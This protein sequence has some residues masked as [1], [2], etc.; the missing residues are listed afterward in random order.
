MGLSFRN[1]VLAGL[2]SAGQLITFPAFSQTKPL[3]AT[4][5]KD[6]QSNV[7]VSPLKDVPLSKGFASKH[8]QDIV[9]DHV[10]ITQRYKIGGGDA[11]SAVNRTADFQQQDIYVSSASN[12][13]SDEIASVDLVERKTELFQ[14]IYFSVNSWDLETAGSKADKPSDVKKFDA[15][16]IILQRAKQIVA[17][18]HQNKHMD[19]LIVGHAS[20]T[21]TEEH[22]L[23][24]SQKRTEAVS[25][26][27]KNA[28]VA[29][30]SS[31]ESRFHL[32]PQSK[33]DLDLAVDTKKEN[34]KNRNVSILTITDEP[35]DIG[36]NYRVNHLSSDDIVKLQAHNNVYTLDLGMQTELGRGLG[37]S[38][39]TQM[40]T[41]A[42]GSILLETSDL[43]RPV[44][45]DVSAREA[46]DFRLLVNDPNAKLRYLITGDATATVFDNNRAIANLNYQTADK[47]VL[48]KEDVCVAAVDLKGG[49]YEKDGLTMARTMPADGMTREQS[50][51]YDLARR[52]D[53][54][55]N[56][57]ITRSE[58]DAYSA[59]LDELN[60]VLP[61]LK[62]A[63]RAVFRNEGGGV[64]G[65]RSQFSNLTCV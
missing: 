63:T 1:A 58:L 15:E 30:D 55:G 10:P 2:V 36:R 43:V 61:Y 51:A 29:L 8:P 31:L 7:I 56:H 46:N 50:F 64:D 23:M 5:R 27:L 60:G 62:N 49:T 33:G 13:V 59:Q 41:S 24:L 57:H 52:I 26:Y 12:E 18:L 42:R 17:M 45:I 65:R 38:F 34:A 28:V 4:H 14:N 21:S 39:S 37:Q 6:V 40:V 54:D 3:P 53:K 20:K 22:N 25:S 35:T 47:K 9:V 44:T 16:A 19:I 11:H 48:G 32:L